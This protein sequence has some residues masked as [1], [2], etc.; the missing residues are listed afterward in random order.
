MKKP[1]VIMTAEK[2]SRLLRDGEIDG[3][4]TGNYIVAT[5]DTLI[6]YH[7]PLTRVFV[8]KGTNMLAVTF[9]KH[10]YGVWHKNRVWNAFKRDW[11][12]TG[13]ALVLETWKA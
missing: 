7:N 1:H 13:N 3:F 2:A 5:R 11:E 10:H 8:P 6:I 9:S 12:K 4:S